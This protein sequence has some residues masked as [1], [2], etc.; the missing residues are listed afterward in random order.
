MNVNMTRR[1]GMVSIKSVRPATLPHEPGTPHGPETRA[2]TKSVTIEH[3]EIIIG[4]LITV[5]ICALALFGR[6]VP[7]ALSL[8][9]TT[10]IGYYFGSM[11]AEKKDAESTGHANVQAP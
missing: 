5:T 6:E 1:Y 7:Q 4:V 8:S 11:R 2:S 10:I 3:P 9:L